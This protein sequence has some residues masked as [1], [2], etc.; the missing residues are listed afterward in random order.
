MGKDNTI[1]LI[2]AGLAAG[3]FLMPQKV[4][5]VITPGSVEGGGSAMP[6][7]D[8][9]GLFAGL[10]F[11]SE[12]PSLPLYDL[13]DIPTFKWPEMPDIP[14]FKW[15]DIPKMPDDWSKMPEIPA[16]APPSPKPA[17]NSSIN[18]LDKLLPNIDI[19][20]VR[21]KA[22]IIGGVGVGGLTAYG[23]KAAIP[24]GKSVL[25]TVT[26]MLPRIGTKA[27]TR[28]AAYFIPYLGWAYLGADIGATIYELISGKNIAGGWLG[29]GEMIQG[30][31]QEQ[32]AAPGDASQQAAI[33]EAATGA[34]EAPVAIKTEISPKWQE[35]AEQNIKFGAW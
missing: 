16:L 24:V 9:S 20:A 11:N 26:K 15:P 29:W 12:I 8:L 18:W 2:A 21:Q 3:Y 34:P 5:E 13:P 4:K 32:I 23:T 17:P 30:E 7:I 22:G 25:S 1:L 28:G 31:N 35:I 19:E 14:P 10:K 27:A 6:D 33:V